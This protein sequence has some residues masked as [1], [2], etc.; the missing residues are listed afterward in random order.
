MATNTSLEY[1]QKVSP[2]YHLHLNLPLDLFKELKNP[3]KKNTPDLRPK[4]SAP[5]KLTPASTPK[6][7]TLDDYK[8]K[9]IAGAFGYNYIEYKKGVGDVEMGKYFEKIRPYLHN[10]I[11]NFKI[12]DKRKIQKH[13]EGLQESMK[14]SG[15]VFDHVDELHYKSQDKPQGF[16][17]IHR[18]S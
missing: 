16:W 15:F 5:K 11:N 17:I 10:M 4:I 1:N 14:G 13:Q 6:K 12:S 3:N 8:P 7:H 9:E 18:F 2:Q